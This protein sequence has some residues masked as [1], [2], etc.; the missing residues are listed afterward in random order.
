LPKG[1]KVEKANRDNQKIHR[2]LMI[3]Q[4]N[5]HKN[6]AQLWKDKYFLLA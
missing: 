1:E 3:V 5:P 6:R 2:K 4:H